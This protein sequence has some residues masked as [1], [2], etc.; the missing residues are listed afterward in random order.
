MPAGIWVL[1][2]D[3]DTDT[4]EAFVDVLRL[5]QM[6]VIEAVNGTEAYE[7]FVRLRPQVI[8]SDLWMSD[9]DGLALIQRV[10]ARHPKD[11]GLT[12]AIALSGGGSE[13]EA[14]AAGFDRYLVKPSEPTRLVDLIR[15]LLPP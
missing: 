5:F 10:R 9:G 3:D 15:E 13:H 1:F 6:V 4:R 14:L 2:V 7:A 12:P 8:V 11:G